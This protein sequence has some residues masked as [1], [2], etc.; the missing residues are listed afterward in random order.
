MTK[1]FESLRYKINLSDYVRVYDNALDAIACQ[2]LIDSFDSDDK[3][4]LR[5]NQFMYFME[6]N[7]SRNEWHIPEVYQSLLEYRQTYLNDL[8]L[9][10]IMLGA[11]HSYE[12]IRMRKFR[13]GLGDHFFPHVDVVG[14]RTTARQLT[15]IWWLNEASSSELDFMRLDRDLK[16]EPAVG[17]LVVF[18]STWQYLYQITEPTDTDIYQLVGHAHYTDIYQRPAEEYSVDDSTIGE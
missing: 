3:T 8:E 9:P 7:I 16:I 5:E 6:N 17:R 11:E 4:Q 12:E 15:F 13:S 14:N 2:S 10:E 18:P 1:E